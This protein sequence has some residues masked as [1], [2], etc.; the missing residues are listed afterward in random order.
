MMVT[1][2]PAVGGDGAGD[3]PLRGPK[4]SFWR[5][6]SGHIITITDFFKEQ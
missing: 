2:F 5:N 3:H 1:E 4:A 6:E